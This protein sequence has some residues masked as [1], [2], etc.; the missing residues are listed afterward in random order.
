MPWRGWWRAVRRALFRVAQE[1]RDLDDELQFHLRQETQLMV[2]RGA[3]IE[4]AQIEARRAFGSVALAKEKTRAVWVS[5][6][7][8]QVFQDLRF[9]CRILWKSPALTATA[10]TMLALVIGGNTTIFSI[11]YGILKKPAPGVHRTGLMTVSWVDD[12]GWVEPAASYAAYLN[13]LEQGRTIRPLLAI[14]FG[15]FTLSDRNGSYAVRGGM[16]SPTYFD[17]LGVRFVQGRGFTDDDQPGTSDLVAVVSHRAWQEFMLSAPDVIG[18]P[19]AI[20]GH[21]ATVVGVVD[22][23]FRGAFLAESSDVW[24]P[25]RKSVV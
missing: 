6:A 5:T 1:D 4:Q 17:A 15:R 25:D 20:N 7:V 8:E 13:F 11:A 3:S 19:I 18:R 16:V 2:D 9:G 24:V 14:E 23:E 10:V 21:P 22:R 12:T